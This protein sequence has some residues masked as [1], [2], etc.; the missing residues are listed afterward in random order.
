MSHPKITDQPPFKSQ[1][2]VKT[3]QAAGKEARAVS[4]P[5][6]SAHCTLSRCVTI[7]ALKC[8]LSI[9]TYYYHKTP[10]AQAAP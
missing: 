7:I 5:G 8:K 9:K 3:H 2:A 10:F 6:A 4:A 1:Q